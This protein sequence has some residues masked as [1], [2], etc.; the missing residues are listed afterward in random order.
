[1]KKKPEPK[2]RKIPAIYMGKILKIW[3]FVTTFKNF[4]LI[5]IFSPEEFFYA[6]VRRIINVEIFR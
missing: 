6:L 3:D 1:L 2:E 5:S 4:L